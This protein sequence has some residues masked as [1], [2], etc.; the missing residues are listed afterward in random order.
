MSLCFLGMDGTEGTVPHT[1]ARC[2]HNTDLLT[3]DSQTTPDRPSPWHS[4][5]ACRVKGQSGF[6]VAF[7]GDP[8][9]PPPLR[10]RTGPVGAA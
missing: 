2:G 1:R 9:T 7:G 5:V 8:L 4:G 10:A 3:G 6:A